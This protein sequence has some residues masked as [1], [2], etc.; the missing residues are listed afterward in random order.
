M[1]A[2][3]LDS[4]R[5]R[6]RAQQRGL[7]WP[8]T[9]R[10]VHARLREELLE[11]LEWTRIEPAR[12]LDLGS[13]SGAAIQ[14]LRARYPDAEIVALDH[15]AD[16]LPKVDDAAIRVCAAAEALPM[17]DHSLDLVFASLTLAYCPDLPACLSETRRVL[18]TP[19][20]FSFVTLGRDSLLELGRAWATADRFAHIPPQ[21]DMHDLGD[22]LVKAGFSEPVL[23]TELIKITYAEPQRL[24]QDLRAAGAY[25]DLAQRNPGLTGRDAAVRL[26]A[27]L[28]TL[29]GADGRFNITLEVVFGQAWTSATTRRPRSGFQ[30]ISPEEIGGLKRR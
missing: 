22:L 29:A 11:R 15:N 30:E 23:D 25:N 28:R 1:Q 3:E 7:A 9:E 6:R 27:A 13:G 26:E 21:P 24:W 2:A 8:D 17:P 10:F 16:V 12:V 20:L 4:R 5:R 18:R 14:P 19:G